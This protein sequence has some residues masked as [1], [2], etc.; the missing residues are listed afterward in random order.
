MADEVN[1]ALLSKVM[2]G[3]QFCQVEGLTIPDN[4]NYQILANPTPKP[5]V[6]DG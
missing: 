6:V 1:M 5:T 3:I 4:A 2:P